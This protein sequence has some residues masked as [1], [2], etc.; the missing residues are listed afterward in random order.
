MFIKRLTPSTTTGNALAEK[1]LSQET[2][3][4]QHTEA[5][6]DGKSHSRYRKENQTVSSTERLSGNLMQELAITKIIVDFGA[7]CFSQQAA[8]HGHHQDRPRSVG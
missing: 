4:P 2:Q 5:L 8:R 7:R 3:D 1:M 6:D